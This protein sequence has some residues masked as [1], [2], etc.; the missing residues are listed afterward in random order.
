MNRRKLA[1]ATLFSLIGLGGISSAYVHSSIA[2]YQNAAPCGKLQGIPGL[3]QS[4]N[5]IPKSDCVYD[6]KKARCKD[7]HACEFEDPTTVGVT[8]KGNC[9]TVSNDCVCTANPD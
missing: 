9:R 6:A 5:L 4:A 3:L 8:L 2:Q 7:S 1:F